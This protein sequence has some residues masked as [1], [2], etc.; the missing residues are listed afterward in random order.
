MES[1]STGKNTHSF[2]WNCLDSSLYG[3]HDSGYFEWGIS[4]LFKIRNENTVK[5]GFEVSAGA[6][7]SNDRIIVWGKN[8]AVLIK[9]NE[10][11]EK[12]SSK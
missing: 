1:L 10:I 8:E 7:A 6:M 12:I 2:C 5:L 11:E 9:N 3:F 4:H